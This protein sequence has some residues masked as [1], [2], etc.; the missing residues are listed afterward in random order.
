MIRVKQSFDKVEP[1]LKHFH[2]SVSH[3]FAFLQA[4]YYATT[5][6]VHSLADVLRTL[7][8]ETG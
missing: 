3:M 4:A 8:V 6:H 5:W 1:N 2:A 7:E